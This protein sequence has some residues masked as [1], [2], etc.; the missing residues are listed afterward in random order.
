MH[1]K[2]RTPPLQGRRGSFGGC[3]SSPRGQAVVEFALV[4][5]LVLILIFIIID[6]AVG[7]N[8]WIVITNAARE[9]ARLGA[10]GTPPAEVEA[11][12]VSESGGLLDT[13]NGS[14]TVD[15]QDLGADGYPADSGDSVVVKVAYQ[16]DLIS[17]LKFFLDS[18]SDSFFLSSCSSMRLERGVLGVTSTGVTC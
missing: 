15:Y 8:N 4:L 13:P 5:P 2:P 1:S 17:P 18:V 7:L 6:F 14:V 10:V 3:P 16:Y 11:R 12:T 9:G